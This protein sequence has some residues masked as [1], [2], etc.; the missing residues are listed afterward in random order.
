MAVPFGQ[1]VGNAL[2]LLGTFLRESADFGRDKPKRAMRCR[3]R[4]RDKSRNR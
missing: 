2:A 4:R 1:S 3:R